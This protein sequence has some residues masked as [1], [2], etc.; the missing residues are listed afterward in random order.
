LPGGLAGGIGY[1]RQSLMTSTL[2]NYLK[3]AIVYMRQVSGTLLTVQG[4]D[5]YRRLPTVSDGFMMVCKI[6]DLVS[7]GF[8]VLYNIYRFNNRERAI[9]DW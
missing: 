1:Q 2:I 5:G 6:Y 3:Y 4:V 9:D 7:L 8:K